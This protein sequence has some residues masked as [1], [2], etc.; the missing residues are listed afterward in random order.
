MRRH[1]LWLIALLTAVCAGARAQEQAPAQEQV[2]PGVPAQEGVQAQP[3]PALPEEVVRGATV[4]GRPRPDYDPVG[5]RVGGFIVYPDLDVQETYDSNV[6]ATQTNQKGD[7]F[8]SMVPSVDVRSDWNVHALNF[9]ADSSVNKY[10]SYDRA[11]Y[12]DYTAG[13]DGRLDIYHDARMYDGLAFLLRHE[14]FS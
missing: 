6:F 7:L 11:D 8:T 2:P 10:I 4:L 3:Q 12:T 14:P 9:H 1:G 5:Q 13:T